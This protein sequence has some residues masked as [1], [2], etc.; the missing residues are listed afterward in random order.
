MVLI[1][2][3]TSSCEH[4]PVAQTAPFENMCGTELGFSTK[5]RDHTPLRREGRLFQSQRLCCCA[6]KTLLLEQYGH[7][8]DTPE[9]MA[10]GCWSP[11]CVFR[12]SFPRECQAEAVR[13]RGPACSAELGESLQ[14]ESLLLWSQWL[15]LRSCRHGFSEELRP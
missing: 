10:E 11:F 5:G 7:R 15:C 13:G 14:V 9:K 12:S 6:F 2:R 8:T 4:S 3:L 1:V